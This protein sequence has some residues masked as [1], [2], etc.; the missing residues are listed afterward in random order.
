M[1]HKN[2]NLYTLKL[3]IYIVASAMIGLILTPITK[4]VVIVLKN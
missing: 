1:H 4:L 2:D 3:I